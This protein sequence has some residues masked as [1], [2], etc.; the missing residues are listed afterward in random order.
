MLESGNFRKIHETYEMIS[1]TFVRHPFD[2]QETFLL[3][4]CKYRVNRISI[5]RLVSAFKDKI[6]K[7]SSSEKYLALK[8]RVN[9]SFP[10]FVDFVYEDI[11]SCHTNQ[12][13]LDRLICNF[14]CC[15]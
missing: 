15:F 13:D 14:K 8:Q 1:F 6:L 10:E 9:G 7:E 11:K 4:I 2:R 12:V 5:Y 3:Q